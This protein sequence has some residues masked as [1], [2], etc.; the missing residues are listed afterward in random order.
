MSKQAL[1]LQ[2]NPF[3]GHAFF[4]VP[5]LCKHVPNPGNSWEERLFLKRG[6]PEHHSQSEATSGRATDQWFQTSQP[7]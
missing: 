2:L 6:S 1:S 3:R 5:P 4:D 7:E